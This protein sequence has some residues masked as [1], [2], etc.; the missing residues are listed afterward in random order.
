[1]IIRSRQEWIH[2]GEK[3]TNYFCNLENR[4]YT[5]KQMTFLE[6]N[7]N[8]LIFDNESIVKETKNFY[9][10]LYSN[11][12]VDNVNLNDLAISPNKLNNL[13]KERLEGK[14]TY[15]EAQLALKDM[16]NNKSPGS[17]GFSAEFLKFFFINIGHFLV[18]SLNYGFDTGSLSI[19]QR[20][21]IITCIPKEN[22][23]KRFLKNWRPISLLNVTYKIASSCIA[24]RMKSCLDRIISNDQKGFMAGRYLGENIRMIYDII[25]HTEREKLPGLLLLVDFE[26]AFDSISWVFISKVLD[27]LNFGPI[28]RKWIDVFYSEICSCVSVNGTYSCWFDIERGVRQGDPLSPYLYLICA[29]VLSCMLRESEQVKGININNVEFLLSQFADDTAIC[30]D[31]SEESFNETIQ[32]LSRFAQMSGLKI[33]FEK[34]VATWIGSRK[35]CNIRYLRDKNFCW[36]PGIFTYLGIKFSL[37]VLTI[38]EINYSTKLD[39]IRKILIVWKRRQLTPF[40]KI[41]VLKTLAISKITHLFLTIPDPSDIFLTQLDRMFF[42]FLWNDKPSK[43]HRKIVCKAYHNGGL[44]MIDIRNFLCKM[45]TSWIKRIFISN[46]P[47]KETTLTFFPCLRN[48]DKMGTERYNQILPRIKNLFWIDVIKQSIILC[49]KITPLNIDEFNAEFIF[50]NKNVQ[51]DRTSFVYQNWIDNDVFQ[52]HHLL[53]DEGNYL[54]LGDFM[55]KFPLINTNFIQYHGVIRAI[56]SYQQKL[57]LHTEINIKRQ[58]QKFL[59]CIFEGNRK[60]NEIMERHDF[61]SASLAKWGLIFEEINWEDVFDKCH[62]TSIDCKLK[63]LQM[64]IIY[65]IIPTNRFLYIRKIVDDSTCEMCGI[66][67]EDLKHM[68]YTCE[69]VS[70]FWNNLKTLL[71]E[72]CNHIVNLDFSEEL[73]FFG[74]KKHMYTDKVFDLILLCAK[75]YLY[76]LKWSKC[77]PCIKAFHC[78]IKSRYNVERCMAKSLNKLNDFDTKWLPYL[79]FLE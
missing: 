12:E 3:P 73:V 49:K 78:Q 10:D 52:I 24:N 16:K 6:K 41:T 32:I 34:T 45:K 75:Y 63:W 37:D 60:L 62:K 57:N 28:F 8:T 79:S 4:N 42:Q 44:N 70:R 29:E 35:N 40:G 77:K 26:K 13:E 64:R 38:P 51:I 59:Q 5:S 53:D 1:M 31:G 30:L 58:R 72:K 67:E 48:L 23:D 43:I 15:Q 21:G 46:T 66:E 18:R 65:R 22:K 7:D 50:C 11:K 68:F 56:Q 33:N 27:F 54:S 47:F 71:L 9:Q 55:T 36:D 2:K 20:Q 69:Y 14:I 61:L 17:D 76:S 25:S 39:E 74:T 19:T